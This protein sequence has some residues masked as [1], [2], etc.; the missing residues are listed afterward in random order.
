[1]LRSADRRLA[2]N[3]TVSGEVFN[4]NFPEHVGSGRERILHP[5]SSEFGVSNMLRGGDPIHTS[6]AWTTANK[7]LAM[8]FRLQKGAVIYQLGWRNG[9]G[10]MTDSVDVGIYDTA[11]N[12]KVSGGGTARSGVS[13]IQWVDVTDT[14]LGAGTYY[15]AMANNG[16]TAGNVY[17]LMV[18]TTVG[19]MAVVG[20][21][22]SATSSYPLPDPLVG[23]GAAATFITIPYM[24]IACRVP[25]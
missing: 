21:Q 18:T 9:S 24:F 23:M 25:F 14:F 20:M 17:N 5:G 4:Q 1:M 6:G 10:T 12:R 2:L 16:T 22:D 19:L 11:W 13:A 8:P 7:P 15:F 3:D